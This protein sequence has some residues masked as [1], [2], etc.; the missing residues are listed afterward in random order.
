MNKTT[1]TITIRLHPNDKKIIELFKDLYSTMTDSDVIHMIL[2]DMLQQVDIGSY[3]AYPVQEA[4]PAL[5]M[6]R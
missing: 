4:L 6:R 3:K 1:T 5:C 2:N